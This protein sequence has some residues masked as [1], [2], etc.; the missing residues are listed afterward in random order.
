MPQRAEPEQDP[1][2]AARVTSVAVPGYAP[3]DPRRLPAGLRFMAGGAFF[4]SIMSLLVKMAGQR[5]PSQEVVFVRALITLALSYWA[6]RR[7]GER[8][9]GHN[10]RLLLTRGALGFVA[11]SGFYYAVVHLPL[12]DA[13]VIQYTNPVYASLLAVPFLGERLRVREMGSVAASLVGVVLVTRP[14]FLFGSATAALDPRAVLFGL[15]GAV[16]SGGAYVA[17]RRLRATEHPMVIILYFAAVSV[18]G[19]APLG[20]WNAVWPTAHEWLLLLGV[21]ISTQLGQV[22]ITHG[23]HL[24]RA[25]RATAVGYLQ[26]V[27][28]AAWGA[29]F[30]GD[31]P[32]LSTWA[33]TAMIVASTL[34]LARAG[35][36]KRERPAVS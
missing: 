31:L 25:G 12:A 26:I 19:S 14:S 18:V 27:F 2:P 1:V 8:L 24:E 32:E 35:G 29:L 13:T 23:L 28:A 10:Q 6:V 9:R 17:V 3:W 15:V 11:L 20:L 22:C 21:G 4:F 7:V 16:A 34:L 36:G 5:L 30:F 33:G